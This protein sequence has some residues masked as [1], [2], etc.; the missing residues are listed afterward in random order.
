MW[1]CSQSDAFQYAGLPR[2]LGRLPANIGGFGQNA[3]NWEAMRTMGSRRGSWRTMPVTVC[4]CLG[5]LTAPAA[6]TADEQARGEARMRRAAL[7]QLASEQIV[8]AVDPTIER[9]QDLARATGLDRPGGLGGLEA[10]GAGRGA[11]RA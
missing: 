1:T 4:V 5:I 7:S 11:G 6:I 8:E 2:L 3:D 10:V 9:L